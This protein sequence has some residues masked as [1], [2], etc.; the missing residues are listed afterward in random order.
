[1][2]ED[3][4]FLSTDCFDNEIDASLHPNPHMI[5]M[6][7]KLL[8]KEAPEIIFEKRGV[9]PNLMSALI[10]IAIAAINKND[11]EQNIPRNMMLSV[12]KILT[13]I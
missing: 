12:I 6:I 3:K 1:M 4:S 8:L 13:P 9:A 7:T 10:G 5:V 2:V 11:K